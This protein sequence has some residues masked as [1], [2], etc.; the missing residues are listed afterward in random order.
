MERFVY[1]LVYGS[2]V[3][4]GLSKT[5]EVWDAKVKRYDHFNAKKNES[6]Y[7]VSDMLLGE[8]FAVVLLSTITGPFKI[9]GTII[10]N[11]NKLD[12]VRKGEKL[13]DYGYDK[14]K[15]YHEYY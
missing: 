11:L 10:D 12:I 9:T 2:M 15:M 14:E 7:V 5:C 6:G 13:E 3:L 4:N 1:R 8:K